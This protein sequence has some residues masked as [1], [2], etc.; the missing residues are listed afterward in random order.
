MKDTKARAYKLRRIYLNF[1]LPILGVRIDAFKGKPSDKTALYVCNHRSFSD[2]IIVCKFIDA[3]VI[4]K[5]EVADLPLIHTGAKLTG[6]T[7]VK[8]E[9]VNSRKSTRKTL[10]KLLMD[11]INVLVYPEGTTSGEEKTLEYRMGSFKE[12]AENNFVVVPIALEYKKQRDLWVANGLVAQF[13]KQYSKL[14]THV[15]MEIGGEYSSND[16]EYLRDACMNW[17]NEAI[18]KMHQGWGSFFDEK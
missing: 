11:D 9:D 10:V 14:S 1:C 3:N 15:K 13:F 5:A 6:V 16:P 2:P 7:Y 8:R 12:A 4:A 17:T 18:E